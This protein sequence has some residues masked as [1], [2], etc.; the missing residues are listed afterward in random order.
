MGVWGLC[1]FKEHVI[2]VINANLAALQYLHVCI[3]SFADCLVILIPCCDLLSKRLIDL[4][5]PGG[6]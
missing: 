6:M 5:K 2:N 1:T 3:L 4:S